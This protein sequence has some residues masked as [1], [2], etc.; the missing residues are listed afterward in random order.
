MITGY[1]LCKYI[2]K[3]L[4]TCSQAIRNVLDQYNTAATH[5]SPIQSALSWNDIVQYTFLADFDLLQETC[6]DVCERAWAC[7]AA[8]ITMD[9]HFQ[10][11]QAEKEIACLDIKIHQVITHLHDEEKFLGA[12]EDNVWSRD[13]A[14]THQLCHY[15][16]QCGLFSALY[17]KQFHQLGSMSG[18]TSSL[19]PGDATDKSL[20]TPI[21]CVNI[22]TPTVNEMNLDNPPRCLEEETHDEQDGEPDDEQNSEQ[23]GKQDKNENEYLQ[24]QFDIIT[25]LQD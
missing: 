10:I 4:K 23:D 3:A 14:L 6:E 1:K 19:E 16:L 2:A 18:F 5:L 22:V 8:R 21:S 7:P 9:Q 24:A 11:I 17:Q 13:P 25:A 20:R 15:W 12:Y